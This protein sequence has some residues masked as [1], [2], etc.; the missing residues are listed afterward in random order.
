MDYPTHYANLIDKARNRTMT[1]YVERHHVVPRCM[2]GTDAKSNIV[3]LSAREHFV[4]HLLLVKIFPKEHKLTCAVTFL[5]S[6]GKI[7]NNKMYDWIRKRHAETMSLLNSGSGNFM[8]GKTH[9][10]EARAIISDKQRQI[11][12]LTGQGSTAGI[13][14][15]LPHRQKISD[16]AKLRTGSKNSFFGKKHSDETKAILSKKRGNSP[17]SNA[18][19]IMIDGKVYQH[20]RE[21]SDALG[22][23]QETI[24]YR[25]NSKSFPNYTWIV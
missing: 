1:G 6:K 21:A 16:A 19:P 18:K 12:Q 17:P 9:T 14:K 10:A 5:T 22:I 25:A 11:K 13:K 3:E 2:G 20:R 8:Y 4:A 23:K 15:S 24:W 7:R